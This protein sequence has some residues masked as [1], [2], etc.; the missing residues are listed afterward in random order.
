MPSDLVESS[1]PQPA[2]GATTIP[3]PYS[4][5][6]LAEDDPVLRRTLSDFLAGEGFLVRE[7]PDVG[8]LRDALRDGEPTALVLDV[9]LGEH[10]VKEILHELRDGQNVVLMSSSVLA[11]DIARAH[12]MTLLSKPFDLDALVQALLVPLDD[13]ASDV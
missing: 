7:A 4:V 10:N 9:H 8:T 1:R 12:R 13:R 11:E 3:Q 6:V 2:V 5:V